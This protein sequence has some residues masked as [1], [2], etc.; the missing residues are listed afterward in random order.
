MSLTSLLV[1][2]H[3]QGLRDREGIEINTRGKRMRRGLGLI[4]W[5]NE[6]TEGRRQH[7]PHSSTL[8]LAK[9]FAKRSVVFPF[10]TI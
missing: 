4:R 1:S 6:M 2:C 9:E 10:T 8:Q 7:L 3:Q 5:G